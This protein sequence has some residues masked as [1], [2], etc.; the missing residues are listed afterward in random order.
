MICNDYI[1]TSSGRIQD[2]LNNDNN[3]KPQERQRKSIQLS[4][5]LDEV[6]VGKEKLKRLSHPIRPIAQCYIDIITRDSSLSPAHRQIFRSYLNTYVNKIPFYLRGDTT[7][8]KSTN[9]DAQSDRSN[10][11]RKIT[12]AIVERTDQ[13]KKHKT[14][15]TKLL[16]P[17]KLRSRKELKQKV[18]RTVQVILAKKVKAS[19]KKL[20]KKKPPPPSS[21]SPVDDISDEPPIKRQRRQDTPQ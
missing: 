7:N 20:P 2:E 6:V 18:K 14:L 9:T 10:L 19:K 11:K 3:N 1:V 13:Q 15:L 16:S 21:S 8:K 5:Q 17:K 12:T 4:K